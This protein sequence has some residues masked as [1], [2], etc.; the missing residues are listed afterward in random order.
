VSCDKEST[1]STKLIHVAKKDRLVSI[2]K[3][4]IEKAPIESIDGGALMR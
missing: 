1:S 2:E 4:T 3:Q